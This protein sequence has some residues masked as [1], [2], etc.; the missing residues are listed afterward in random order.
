M[1][2]TKWEN[3]RELAQACEESG[4]S[5][6]NWCKKNKIPYTSCRNWFVRLQQENRFSEPQPQ[7]LSVWGKVEINQQTEPGYDKQT[8]FS[9]AGIKLTYGN[10]GMEINCGFD[11]ML[12][13]QIMQV[14]ET[15]C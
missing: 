3:W 1:R 14:V 10:W 8:Y 5:V 7:E 13:K 4:M 6:W 12:L 15:R 2:G 11:Q 9:A